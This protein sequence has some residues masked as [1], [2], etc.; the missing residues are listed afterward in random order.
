MAYFSPLVAWFVSGIVQL[1]TCEN[2]AVVSSIALKY[3]LFL[4]LIG[5]NLTHWVTL[6]VIVLKHSISFN[7]LLFL[8]LS[9]TLFN[10]F[11]HFACHCSVHIFVVFFISSYP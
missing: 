4:A 3:S 7:N 8:F 11:Q 2:S 1:V 9:M 5:F 10:Y 6:N